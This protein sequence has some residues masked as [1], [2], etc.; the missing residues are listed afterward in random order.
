MG[1]EFKYKAYFKAKE[2]SLED[3]EIFG[4]VMVFTFKKNMDT[5]QETNKALD[6]LR[7]SLGALKSMYIKTKTHYFESVQPF[8]L[9]LEFI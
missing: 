2:F 6:T 8:H 9:R 7:C 3:G 5:K 1:L 4:D